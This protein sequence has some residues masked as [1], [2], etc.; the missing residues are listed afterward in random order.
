LVKVFETLF[1]AAGVVIKACLGKVGGGT[2]ELHFVINKIEC[3]L[4]EHGFLESTFRNKFRRLWQS[5][6]FEEL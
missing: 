5:A 2:F 1:K 4:G 3:A 6:G